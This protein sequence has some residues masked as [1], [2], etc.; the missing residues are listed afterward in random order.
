MTPARLAGKA[1][2]RQGAI[3]GCT[4]RHWMLL[5]L[6]LEGG[7]WSC[8][9]SS[10]GGEGRPAAEAGGDCCSMRRGLVARIGEGEVGASRGWEVTARR[11]CGSGGGVAGVAGCGMPMRGTRRRD[12]EWD[13]AGG[14]C[15]RRIP[16]RESQ[17]RLPGELF[18]M[19]PLS[20]RAVAA[21]TRAACEGRRC[22]TGG[23][24]RWTGPKG[25]GGDGGE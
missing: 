21:W 14:R 18:P 9:G 1:G 4:G 3:S 22:T 25:R 7:W 5:D 24:R 2:D 15:G 13:P 10:L 12:V 6:G 23:C 8:G 16:S 11:R 20:I 17:I 19:D